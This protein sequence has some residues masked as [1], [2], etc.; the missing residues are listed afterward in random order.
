MCVGFAQTQLPQ[1]KAVSIVGRLPKTAAHVVLAPSQLERAAAMRGKALAL[2]ALLLALDISVTIAQSQ[3]QHEIYKCFIY[4]EEYRKKLNLLPNRYVK[5]DYKIHFNTID[6]NCYFLVS[7]FSSDDTSVTS[8]FY[9]VIKD[10]ILAESHSFI[11]GY[12]SIVKNGFFWISSNKKEKNH[13][14]M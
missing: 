1:Q 7:Y 11:N 9:D 5:F 14:K 10:K 13:M 4:G 8:Y 12:G 3:F 6:E 2:S